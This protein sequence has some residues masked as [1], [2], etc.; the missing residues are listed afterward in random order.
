MDHAMRV[1]VVERVGDR[2]RDVDGFVDGQLLL[3]IEAMT[4]TLAL[5]VRHD[6]VQQAAR[7]ARVEQGQKVRML[8]RGR[9]ANLTQE[10]LGAEHCTQ[11]GVEHFERDASVVLLVAREKHGGHPTAPDLTID[12]VRLAERAPE[13]VLQSRHGRSSRGWRGLCRS[14]GAT[15]LALRMK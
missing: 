6:V 9:H 3:A 10:P 2:R 15:T 5:D 14:I 11:L 13:L 7:F 1:R 12:R 8:Q 4:K